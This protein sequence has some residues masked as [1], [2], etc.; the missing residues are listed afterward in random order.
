MTKTENIKGEPA[1]EEDEPRCQDEEDIRC[2][3]KK[4]ST[5]LYLYCF[6]FT[7]RVKSVVGAMKFQEVRRL[8]Q[9]RSEH[10]SQQK[11][12]ERFSLLMSAQIIKLKGME[13]YAGETM[14]NV[15]KCDQT[16]TRE[17]TLNNAAVKDDITCTN[18][19]NITP[20]LTV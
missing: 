13:K 3:E 7:H 1:A 20:K 12:S 19:N 5:T 17:N 2:Q 11:R 8:S 4:T 6:N 9:Q 18:D 14:H 10:K 16:L 15:K